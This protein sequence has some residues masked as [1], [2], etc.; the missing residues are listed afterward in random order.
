MK[1]KLIFDSVRLFHTSRPKFSCFF[2]ILKLKPPKY[3]SIKVKSVEKGC[4]LLVKSD[5][6]HKEE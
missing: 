6:G 3:P 2:L 5:L 4:F 1:T